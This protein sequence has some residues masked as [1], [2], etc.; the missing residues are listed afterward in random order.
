MA[1]TTPTRS[2]T[3]ARV[4]STHSTRAVLAAF[5]VEPDRELYG[6]QLL[7]HTGL[8]SGTLYPILRRLHG[9]GWLTSRPEDVDPRQE[10]RP[11]RRYYRLTAAGADHA[12]T[13]L[14]AHHAYVTREGTR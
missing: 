10:S 5:L 3:P 8:H 1:E 7:A 4:V 6:L 2:T 9:R 14:A 13:Y 11:R 12:R